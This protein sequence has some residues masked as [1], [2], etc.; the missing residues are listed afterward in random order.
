MGGLPS[1]VVKNLPADAGDMGLIPGTGRSPKK[2]MA[3]HSSVLGHLIRY[4]QFDY[5][6]NNLRILNSDSRYLPGEENGNPLLYFCLES[7]MDRGA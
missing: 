1:S 3:T 7:P 6:L 5:I 4:V 2:E